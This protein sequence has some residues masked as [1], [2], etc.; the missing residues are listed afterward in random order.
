MAGLRS[1]L[2]LVVQRPAP[3]P[4]I[5]LCKGFEAGSAQLPHQVAAEELAP[6]MPRGVLSGPSFAQEVARGVPAAVTLAATDLG[7]CVRHGA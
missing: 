2:K 4:V 1:T 5:W 6:G 3:V 7:L